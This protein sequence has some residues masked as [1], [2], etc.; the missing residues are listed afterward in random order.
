MHRLATAGDALHRHQDIDIGQRRWH[1]EVSADPRDL[2]GAYTDR[3]V[4]TAVAGALLTVLVTLL[5]Y[6]LSTRRAKAR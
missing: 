4:V 5:V 2:P 6:L 3:P 1:L